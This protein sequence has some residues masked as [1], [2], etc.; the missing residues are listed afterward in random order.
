MEKENGVQHVVGAAGDSG[1]LDDNKSDEKVQEPTDNKEE[2][3]EDQGAAA[4]STSEASGHDGYVSGM[5]SLQ[6]GAISKSRDLPEGAAQQKMEGAV[7]GDL[8]NS[9]TTA[10]ESFGE[11]TRQSRVSA[12]DILHIAPSQILP[13]SVPV[14]DDGAEDLLRDGF[15]GHVTKYEGVA[16]APSE[17]FEVT[18][19]T[20]EYELEKIIEGGLIPQDSIASSGLDEDSYKDFKMCAEELQSNLFEGKLLESLSN[21]RGFRRL[22]SQSKDPILRHTFRGNP[23]EVLQNIFYGGDGIIPED[24]MILADPFYHRK[25]DDFD[26]FMFD[27]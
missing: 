18:W 8:N 15:I 27:D 23:V 11:S 6:I 20:M 19:A 24:R 12:S 21:L 25:K 5:T 7:G 17:E 4:S 14:L 9:S 16:I 1:Q 13:A 3:T 2:S 22:F 26:D 10:R